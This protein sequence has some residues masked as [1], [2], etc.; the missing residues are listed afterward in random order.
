MPDVNDG[1]IG[2]GIG[3]GI[4]GG[5]G[6]RRLLRVPQAVKKP[7]VSLTVVNL[8]RLRSRKQGLGT[9]GLKQLLLL[10]GAES[11]SGNSIKEQNK[12]VKMSMTLRIVLLI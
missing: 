7:R 8:S 10:R 2:V 1:G 4:G 9:Q 11:P 3:G 12:F 5:V 6:G